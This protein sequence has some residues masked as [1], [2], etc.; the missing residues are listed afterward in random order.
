MSTKHPIIMSLLFYK[1]INRSTHN[2][3]TWQRLKCHTILLWLFFA[4]SLKELFRKS[5]TDGVCRGNTMSLLCMYI[6]LFPKA[7]TLT[8]YKLNITCEVIHNICDI[9]YM[10]LL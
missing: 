9:A 5:E 7:S 3:P 2:N 10:L 8:G 6:R 4:F 1:I